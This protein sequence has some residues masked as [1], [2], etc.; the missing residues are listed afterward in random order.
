MN[1]NWQ[2][3]I[4]THKGTKKEKN[5]DAFFSRI[6]TDSKGNEA[7]VF[8]VADGMGGYE[9]GEKASQ[10]AIHVLEK[11]WDRKVPKLLKRKH[12][13]ERI[14]K[15]A[16]KELL[17]INK[18]IIAT[19][20]HLGKK[21][22]TTV[23]ILVLYKGKYGV[24]HIGDSRIYQMKGWTFGLQ[25]YFQRMENSELMDKHDPLHTELLETNPEL[26][27]LTVDH[28]WVEEQIHLGNLSE[29]EAFQHPKRNVLLQCLGIESS[30]NPY[31]FI[32]DYQSSDLF[33][34]C[35]DGFHS[36]FE[37]EEIKNM[38][39]NLEKEYANLQAMCDYLINFSN[40]SHAQDNITLMLIRHLYVDKT[41]EKKKQSLF[42]FL[43]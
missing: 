15:D 30:I 36:L 37:Q 31:S 42:S 13:L 2:T 4:A 16:E 40:F 5:E 9:I 23:S 14:V 38:L 7:A 22:G 34:V 1:T 18:M 6:S 29:D 24:V 8:V 28:T 3:G 27:Q 26:R 35:S 17:Q 33:L 43:N 41:F 25:Q 19:S 12:A 39:M 11:W 21:M 10:I 32:G 20:E